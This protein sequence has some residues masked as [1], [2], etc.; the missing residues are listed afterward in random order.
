MVFVILRAEQCNT[1]SKCPS[2]YRMALGHAM[3]RARL[4]GAILPRRD[5]QSAFTDPPEPSSGG[6]FVARKSLFGIS[7][8][9]PERETRISGLARECARAQSAGPA[10]GNEAKAGHQGWGGP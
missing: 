5:R 9:K 1:E 4:M 6:F 10:G 2:N 7:R 8:R 3:A